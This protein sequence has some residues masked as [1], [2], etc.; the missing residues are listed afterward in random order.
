LEG[1][2]SLADSWRLEHTAA[3]MGRRADE[4]ERQGKLLGRSLA[5]CKLCFKSFTMFT[6]RH[7]CALCFDAVCGACSSHRVVLLDATSAEPA[8]RRVCEGCQFYLEM[9]RRSTIELDDDEAAPP[10]P[11][12]PPTPT[13]P[14]GAAFAAE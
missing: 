12:P 11:P 1:R 3:F 13:T 9:R 7:T 5:S 6:R 2:L 10:P 8:L 4:L 14:T